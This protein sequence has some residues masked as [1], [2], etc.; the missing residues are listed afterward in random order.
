MLTG[1]RDRTVR[2]WD[3]A[4]GAV[5]MTLKG[6]QLSVN[7]VGFAPDGQQVVTGS[8]DKTTRLWDAESGALLAS[9]TDHTDSVRAA[10]FSPDGR[11]I[12]TASA[13][14]TAQ[15]HNIDSTFYA[16]RACAILRGHPEEL[17]AV[18]EIC[19][20]YPAP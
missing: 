2:L 5:L 11:H 3:A 15:I 1:S 20:Q 13:D 18:A 14:G 12:L 8:D 17:R 6:H 19:K 9:F 4:S 7:A 10:S 16:T